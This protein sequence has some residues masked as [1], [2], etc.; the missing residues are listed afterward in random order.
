M[1]NLLFKSMS[2]KFLTPVN[3]LK[4][5]IIF[6]KQ[7]VLQLKNINIKV[8]KIIECIIACEESTSIL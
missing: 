3:Q 7:E 4:T 1:T 8:D 2:H 5:F 6:I